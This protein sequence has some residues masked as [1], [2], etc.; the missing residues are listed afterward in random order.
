MITTVAANVYRVR[1]VVPAQVVETL[2]LTLYNDGNMM[3]YEDWTYDYG[4]LGFDIAAVSK[5]NVEHRL[6]GYHQ[7]SLM[8]V[9]RRFETEPHTLRI[10]TTDH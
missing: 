7:A 10:P 1:M 6:K 3:S 4:T 5:A 2:V 9:G 8:L